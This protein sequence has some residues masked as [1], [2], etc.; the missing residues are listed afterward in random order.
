MNKILIAI[1]CFGLLL[2]T[3]C[4]IK[5]DKPADEDSF[6]TL[7]TD[8]IIENTDV[9]LANGFDFPVGNVDG[10]GSYISL[11]DKKKYDSWYVAVATG[12]QIKFGI[13]TGE[14]WT[15][16]G[17]SNTDLGQPVYSIGAGIVISAKGYPSPVGKVVAIEHRYMENDTI[18]KIISLYV[19]MKDII[20]KKGDTV[21]RREQI[22]TIGNGGGDLLSAHLHLEIRKSLIEDYP[23]LY[24]PS[25]DGKD[26]T[27]I[28]TNY[29]KPTEFIN[30]HRKLKTLRPTK[31]KHH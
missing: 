5:D 14:D 4:L 6:L 19:H 16:S 21:E 8:T 15:G 3:S 11:I 20:V 9:L 25:L 26:R 23:I 17:G 29:E 30:K 28:L 1:I 2:L 13:H 7:D 24:W 10:K 31:N 12:D 27:W 18:K 22:G